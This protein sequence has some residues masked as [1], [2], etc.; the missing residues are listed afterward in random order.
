MR[1]SEANNWPP[2]F[3]SSIPH[4][5]AHFI[6]HMKAP[7]SSQM[8]SVHAWNKIPKLIRNRAYGQGTWEHTFYFGGTTDRSHCSSTWQRASAGYVNPLQCIRFIWRWC[9]VSL[10]PDP[11]YSDALGRGR[12]PRTT[13]SLRATMQEIQGGPH[14][15]EAQWG[16]DIERKPAVAIK[17]VW[18]YQDRKTAPLLPAY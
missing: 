14:S 3:G 6:P 12:K 17:G 13:P 16:L 4:K 7:L 1:C 11:R 2:P 15:Q 18:S 10:Q 9:N 8:L 5:F